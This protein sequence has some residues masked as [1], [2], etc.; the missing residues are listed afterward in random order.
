M[1]ILSLL[2]ALLV[3]PMTAQDADTA[4]DGANGENGEGPQEL[5]LETIDVN[6]INIEAF[7]TDK[8]GNRIIGLKK[9]DFELF[10]DGKPAKITNFY[11]VEDGKAQIEEGPQYIREETPEEEK[12]PGIE[13]EIE[14]PP[15]QKLHLVVY[16]DN[17]NLHPFSRNR[18]FGYIRTFLRTRLRDAVV[19][20]VDRGGVVLG[21]CNGFQVLAKMGLLP[22]AEAR[23][24]VRK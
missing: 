20:L 4:G 22:G 24:G 21:I 19:D 15:E 14:V 13:E 5:F 10:V 3:L 9:D 18:A 17:Y 11:A 16:V 8:K 2:L 7:V 6:L 23:I 1:L 12:I